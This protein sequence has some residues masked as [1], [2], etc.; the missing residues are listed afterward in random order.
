[1]SNSNISGALGTLGDL[2]ELGADVGTTINYEDL[3]LDNAVQ[4]RLKNTKKK[5][6]HDPKFFTMPDLENP[7][8]DMGQT[9]LKPWIFGFGLGFSGFPKPAQD[10]LGLCICNIILVILTCFHLTIFLE[11]KNSAGC[12]LKTKWLIKICIFRGTQIF[13]SNY[14]VQFFHQPLGF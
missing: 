7:Y 9:R 14:N 8:P 12:L 11:K 5:L 10:L 2:N 1:M 4:V 6:E 13:S 3:N